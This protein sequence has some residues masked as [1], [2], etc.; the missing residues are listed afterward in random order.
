MIRAD[1]GV[2]CAQSAPAT[3]PLVSK[4][5]VAKV[6]A[7][8][9]GEAPRA[10]FT[11]FA[12]VCIRPFSRMLRLRHSKVD[13]GAPTTVPSSFGCDSSSRHSVVRFL[14]SRVL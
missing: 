1:V 13:S 7:G 5:K 11:L 3:V 6:G 10:S 4:R 14:D 2:C 12:S 8:P 9:H